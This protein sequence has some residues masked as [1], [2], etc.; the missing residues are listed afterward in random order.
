M[1]CDGPTINL[2]LLKKRKK[3]SYAVI[4]VLNSVAPTEQNTYL[5]GFILKLSYYIYFFLFLYLFDIITK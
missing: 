1:I 5:C 2:S 3:N 4:V